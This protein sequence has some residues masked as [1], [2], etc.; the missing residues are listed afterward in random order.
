[1]ASTKPQK[2]KKEESGRLREERDKVKLIDF[3]FERRQVVG[4]GKGTRRR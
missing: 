4:F 1:M 3:G 2:L